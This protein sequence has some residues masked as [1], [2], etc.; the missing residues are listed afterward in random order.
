MGCCSARRRRWR[1]V[2]VA[3]I[4]G[5]IHL[6]LVTGA[7][8]LTWDY[9]KEEFD[10]HPNP[11]GLNVV[12]YLPACAVAAYCRGMDFRQPDYLM[13]PAVVL[14]I[15]G[16]ML[17]GLFTSTTVRRVIEHAPK[18]FGLLSWRLYLLVIL[19]VGLLPVPLRLSV[20]SQWKEWSCWRHFKAQQRAFT[21]NS[22]KELAHSI[23]TYLRQCRLEDLP[24]NYLWQPGRTWPLTWKQYDLI[25]QAMKQAQPGKSD[26]A[27][28][29]PFDPWE[30]RYQV[31]LAWPGNS[32]MP[33]V[34]IVRSG[35]PDRWLGTRDDIIWIKEDDD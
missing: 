35:G 29:P 6:G 18:P 15:G 2:W 23:D 28:D 25:T 1:T 16:V 5:A 4:L 9:L 13:I 20:Y 17:T 32:Q 24:R 26:A 3:A 30:M 19:W 8:K 14:G 22:A 12:S 34:I 31:V 7:D 33:I 27:E 10:Q 21:Y 11:F